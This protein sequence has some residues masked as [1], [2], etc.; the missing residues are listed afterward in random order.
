MNTLTRMALVAALAAAPLAACTQ[1]EAD[2]AG[3]RTEAAATDATEAAGDAAA[4]AARAVDNAADA[5]GSAIRD[6]A[7]ET[8]DAANDVTT[9]ETTVRTG[10][11]GLEVRTTETQR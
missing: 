4:G 11:D 1:Q 10:D 5:T 2:N 8:R 9:E 6:G 7:S 3:D